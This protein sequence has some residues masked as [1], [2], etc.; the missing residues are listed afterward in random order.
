MNKVQRAIDALR[1]AADA[2]DAV[3]VR[4]ASLFGT[5]VVSSANLRSEAEW[6]EAQRATWR[7]AMGVS[8]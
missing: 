5:A 7:D 1:E 4:R 2:M 6:L 3:P 8:E